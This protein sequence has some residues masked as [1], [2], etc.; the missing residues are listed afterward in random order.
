MYPRRKRATSPSAITDSVEAARNHSEQVRLLLALPAE[1]C[2]AWIPLPPVPVSRPS[3]AASAK[4]TLAWNTEGK[5]AKT[6]EGTK[7]TGY[8]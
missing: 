2:T 7:T 1:Q 5:P 6:A 8:L 3:T 4:Q